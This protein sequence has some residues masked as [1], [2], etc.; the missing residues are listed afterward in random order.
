MLQIK[1]LNKVHE[2]CMDKRKRFTY[3]DKKAFKQ[4]RQ[5]WGNHPN[6]LTIFAMCPIKI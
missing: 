3:G 4:S 6:I 2:L 1:I 5:T